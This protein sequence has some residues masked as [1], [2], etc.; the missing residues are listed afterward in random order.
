M[1]GPNTLLEKAAAADAAQASFENGR[2]DKPA[3]GGRKP[4]PKGDPGPSNSLYA[5]HVK[6]YPKGVKGKYRTIKWAVLIFC[7]AFY[8]LAPWLRWDRGPEAPNQALLIDIG[9]PRAYLF[10]IEIW[11]Q[12]VYFITGLLVLGALG[13][14]LV[15]SLFGRLWCGYACPQTVWTDLFMLV[16]RWI[17]GDRGARMRLDKA[18]WSFGKVWRKL[19]KHSVWFAIALATGGAWALYFNDA[20]TFVVEF[21]TG[22]ASS[23][24]YF[25][26]G[27][28]TAT[29]YVLAGWAREQVCTYMC[30]WPRFQAAMLDDQSMVVTYESWRGEK[31]GPHK[32][33][34]SWEGR[35][36]CIDCGQCV[37]VCPTG[38]DIRDGIQL[39]CIG[40]GL[41]IDSCNE[42]MAKVGRPQELITFDTEARQRARAQGGRAKWQIIRPRVL[43][44]AALLLI[45]SAIMLVALLTRTTVQVSVL[46]DRAPLFVTLSDGGVRNGYTLKILNKRREAVDF[47]LSLEDVPPGALLTVQDVGEARDGQPVVLPTKGDKVATF[48][49]FV[50]L[51]PDRKRDE[52]TEFEFLLQNPVRGEG[53]EYHAVFVGPHPVRR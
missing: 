16:E 7:L 30:P 19:A 51:P 43:I 33:G 38:I 20:P 41:C 13:L 10:N 12:E 24:Q 4:R 5:E 49:V 28:F 44:Y 52:K 23:M 18:P 1:T 27:L 50:T 39:E 37:A 29:T 53:D 15:T 42:I 11:P 25:F 14:F 46:R 35:G 48:R 9:A 17:E 22:T 6:V 26:V 34:T 31:R 8:Y 21:F 40:C 3:P 2:K 32:A 47:R 36:D 45:V